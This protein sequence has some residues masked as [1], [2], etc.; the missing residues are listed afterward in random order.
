MKEIDIIIP[1]HNRSTSLKKAIQSVR[2]QTYP[3]WNLF[4]IEDGS[5][6][7]H[8]LETKKFIEELNDPRITYQ[9][10]IHKG[11]SAT[12]NK[13]VSLGSAPWLAFLDSDDEWLPEKLKMQ[14][15]L[16]D[17]EKLPIVHTEEIWIR[18]GVRVNQKK[19]HQKSGGDI[20]TP[21][22]RRCLISPSSIMI[23]RTLFEELGGFDPE[24]VVCEDYDLWLRATLK[25]PIS[26]VEKPMIAKYGGHEDQLSMRY[27]AMDK[28]RL[29]SMIRLYE[30]E[31]HSLCP[32]KK[33]ALLLEVIYKGEILY[34]GFL[35]HHKKSEALWALNIVNWAK[36]IANLS[37]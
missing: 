14:L 16:F 13:G 2:E 32:E 27:K 37:S 15:D 35:K 19:I 20:F 5:S 28:W 33:K 3:H 26:F 4:V 22:L 18:R 29:K 17:K 30:K 21:S 12:R 9:V 10:E 7:Q 8:I 1:T 6:E 34:Q 23:T 31:E 36:N 11:V 24:F 25:T